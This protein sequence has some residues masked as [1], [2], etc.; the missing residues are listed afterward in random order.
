MT[1]RRR[2]QIGLLNQEYDRRTKTPRYANTEAGAA[3]WARIKQAQRDIFKHRLRL[4]FSRTRRPMKRS[5]PRGSNGT[6]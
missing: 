4:V 6:G 3:V 2:E 1:D 5:K